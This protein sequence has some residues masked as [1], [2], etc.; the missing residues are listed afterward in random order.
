[1]TTKQYVIMFS[2]L[3]A[4]INLFWGGENKFP[5]CWESDI[6]NAVLFENKP[7]IN[8]A[9]SGMEKLDDGVTNFHIEQGLISTIRTDLIPLI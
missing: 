2:F 7:D 3:E 9:L 4:K 8:K 5:Y 6:T 1:M